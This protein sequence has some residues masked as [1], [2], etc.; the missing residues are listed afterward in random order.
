MH[1]H[2]SAYYL[3]K[4]ISSI[5]DCYSGYFDFCPPVGLLT[6]LPCCGI[7]LV[8]NQTD[9]TW[10]KQLACLKDWLLAHFIRKRPTG[11]AHCRKLM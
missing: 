3:L 4:S 8:Y 5:V 7:I 11:E 2:I 10:G 6:L 1:L 9:Q